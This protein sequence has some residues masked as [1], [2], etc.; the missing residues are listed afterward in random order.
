[1]NS[2]IPAAVNRKA[3]SLRKV[4]VES[5]G[6]LG[7]KARAKR[8]HLLDKAFPAF[9]EMDVV[10]LGGTV[11]SWLRAPVRPNNVTVGNLYE[12][13]ESAEP[14]LTPV[15]GDACL[16]QS[17]LGAAGLPTRYDV[18]FSNSLLE[19]V[20]GHAMRC[21]LAGQVK[22]IADFHWIQTPYRY[23][24]I[25]PH[26]LFPMMQF[27]PVNVRT[28]I[29]QTWPLANSRANDPVEAR[30]VVQWTDLIGIAQMR[31]YFPDSEIVLERAFGLT[32][33]L[34]AVQAP[35]G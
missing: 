14:W 22:S 35:V 31:S 7:A 5:P 25:E 29:A 13:G 10:D 34:M 18:A 11:D 20:G 12:P 21:A 23:F 26:W 1:M 24:P 9:R 6:S 8:W 16:A 28:V 17:V 30:S 2:P 19:H 27:M 32:K 4:F 3:R 15:T 33:S